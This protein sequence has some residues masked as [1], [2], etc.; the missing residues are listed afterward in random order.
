M[1]VIWIVLFAFSFAFLAQV[2]SA[3]SRNLKEANVSPAFPSKTV[4]PS[5]DGTTDDFTGSGLYVN[6]KQSSNRPSKGT[7]KGTPYLKHSWHRSGKYINWLTEKLA[8]KLE[9]S[10][11]SNPKQYA[12][13]KRIYQKVLDRYLSKVKQSRTE[14]EPYVLTP[15]NNEWSAGA[16]VG[17][18]PPDTEWG[19]P[20]LVHLK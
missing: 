11:K 14:S 6:D 1:R 12:S 3:P 15:S 17:L 13:L 9:H 10:R 20:A 2:N 18:T 19:P 5:P 7:R 16:S 4:K 8:K